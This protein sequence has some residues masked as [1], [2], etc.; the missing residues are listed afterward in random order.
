VIACSSQATGGLVD[1]RCDD[2]A[3]KEKKEVAAA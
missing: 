2:V 1:G 3:G